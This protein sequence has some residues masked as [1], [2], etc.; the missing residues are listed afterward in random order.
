[1]SQTT[2][3]SSGKKP[4]ITQRTIRP[5]YARAVCTDERTKPG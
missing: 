1:V 3:R 5:R 4:L 2:I